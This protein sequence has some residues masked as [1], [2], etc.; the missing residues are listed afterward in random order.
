MKSAV[1]F[2][3]EFLTSEG[4]P[5]RFLCGPEDPDPVI[6]QIG[7]V[8][9]ELAGNF[10]IRETFREY[11]IPLDRHGTRYPLDPFFTALTGITEDQITMQGRALS[12][13]L[14]ALKDFAAGEKLWSWGKDEFNMIA[15]SCYVQS[16][17]PPIEARRFD[18]ACTL[19][20][21]AGMP[22]DDIKRTRSDG[23]ATY[24]EIDHPPLRG[25]DARDDALSV[26]Y[27]LQHL[28]KQGK[29]TDADFD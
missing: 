20:L 24:F 8:K 12:Q 15:I 17:P 16:L 6:A 9:I 28:L 10:T 21:K 3:C 2:D 23:L 14:G 4:A 22:L 25:H 27:A 19:V 5:N 18:N 13:A 29:L 7:A 11:V 1:I 26:A